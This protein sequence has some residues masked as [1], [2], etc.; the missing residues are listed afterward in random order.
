MMSLYQ[1]LCE[2]L[3]VHPK[4]WLVT[5]VAGFIG[6]SVLQKLLELDQTVVGLDNFST[7]KPWNL[8]NVRQGVSPAAWA[9]FTFIEGDTRDLDTCRQACEGRE[10]VLHQAALG[11]VPRSIKD[12]IA[13]HQSNVDGLLN[14]LVAARD[15][16]VRRMAYA[17]SSSVYGDDAGL[18][19]VEER[20]GH[21]LSPYALTKVI[22][23]QYAAIFARTYGFKTLGFR[24]FNV[25]GPRQNP[26][27]PYA[28][29]MPKW[30]QALADGETCT[31]HGDG[32]TSRDFCFVANAVQA[33]LL[34][35][36]A[37]ESAL[38]EVFN[39]SYGGT[40][41]L[42]NLYWMIV[43]RLAAVHP[44]FERRDPLY[45]PPREGDIRHSQ[46]DLS[47]IRAHLGYEPTHSVAQGLDELVPW[48]AA[49]AARL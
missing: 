43:E 42:T 25:F 12:P 18:P 2:D 36:V 4:R 27:G 10:V 22:G 13:S 32:D 1:A 6:S 23:E 3:R 5:G 24:Y 30:L 49:Q 47:K 38:G 17:S 14:M 44:G 37:P 28:A 16:G 20:T 9:R 21:P 33:N 11:S 48:F 31:I 35:S 46:A 8:E 39:V 34:A 40:T 26:N 41:S 15:A 29:V 19:K 7:G 45:G